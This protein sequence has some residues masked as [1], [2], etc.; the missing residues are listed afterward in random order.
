MQIKVLQWFTTRG[1][2]TH[3]PMV[4]FGGHP[5]NVSFLQFSVSFLQFSQ[6][7]D[8]FKQNDSEDF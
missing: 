6:N 5:E 7:V 3:K 1:S 8:D 2:Y 4:K